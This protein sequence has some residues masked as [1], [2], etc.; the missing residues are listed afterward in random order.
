MIEENH[1]RGAVLKGLVEIQQKGQEQQQEG[2]TSSS[3]KN[4]ISKHVD[5][6]DQASVLATVME[7][8]NSKLY[9]KA[10]ELVKEM[11]IEY[12]KQAIVQK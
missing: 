6:Q 9:L 2:N 8:A 7:Q 5:D 3:I 11:E 10:E 12:K 4:E 1:P